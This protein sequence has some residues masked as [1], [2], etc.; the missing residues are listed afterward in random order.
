MS[1]LQLEGAYENELAAT[2]EF[3]PNAPKTALRLP[4]GQRLVLS[5]ETLLR[6]LAGEET[7]TEPSPAAAVAPAVPLR[8]GV[9]EVTGQSADAIGEMSDQVIPLLAEQLVVGKTNVETGRLR[10][11]RSTEERTETVT[12]PLT[13]VRWEVEHVP[14]GK[15]V[16]TQP[17]I[18]QV[19]D[20]TIFPLVEEKLVVTRELWLR[21][22]VHV[23]KVSTTVE[24]SAEFAVKQDVLIETR[25]AE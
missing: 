7:F 13:E 3:N 4:S 11:R 19:G 2:G 22:E 15:N 16:D 10:L 23:R 14:V 18:R 24:K 5:T 6:A 20:T 1:I 9:P 12:V 17:D 21:E 25:T 8:S